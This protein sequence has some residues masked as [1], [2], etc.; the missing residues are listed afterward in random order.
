[1]YIDAGM[2]SLVFFWNVLG[3]I[4]GGIG[5][6]AGQALVMDCLPAG[7]NGRPLTPAQVRHVALR[8]IESV[9]CG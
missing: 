5:G 9:H 8:I 1:V 7:P 2:Y 6:V 4:L 3:N